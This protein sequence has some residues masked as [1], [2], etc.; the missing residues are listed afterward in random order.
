MNFSACLSS[1]IFNTTFSLQRQLNLNASFALDKPSLRSLQEWIIYPSPSKMKMFLIPPIIFLMAAILIIPFI[2]FVIFSQVNIRRETRYLLLANALLCDFI[3]LIFYTLSTILNVS[4]L[5]LPKSVC[6]VLLF[7][8]AMTYSG[9]L[10]TTAAMVLDTYLAILWPLH[11]TSIMPSSRTKKLILLLWISSGIFP[12]IVFVILQITQTPNLCQVETCSVPVILVMTLHGNDAMKFC[13]VLSV[14]ALFL[15]LFLILGC[16]MILYF[17][18]KQSGIWKSIFSRASVTFLMHHIVL[19][20]HFSPLMALVVESLLYIHG[21]IGLQTGI[22]VSLIVCNVLII[23]P[24]ALSPYLYGLRYREISSSL[25][26]FLR[27]KRVTM[28]T[29][30][31]S[32]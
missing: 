4:N 15:C 13:Y 26:F 1:R 25:K 20:L 10:L 24:K 32:T 3:Y 8:L 21:V 30:V 7:L 29:P 6:V 14:S 31:S 27:R 23:L 18:T 28:I 17:K 12:G 5:K 2:L 19:F 22:W 11:Y 9:G 16:Y